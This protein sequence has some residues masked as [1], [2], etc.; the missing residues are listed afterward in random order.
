MLCRNTSDLRQ[1]ICYI[2]NGAKFSTEKIIY[3]SKDYHGNPTLLSG[4]LVRPN[5][6][7]GVVLFYH[8]TTADRKLSPSNYHGDKNIHE[9]NICIDHFVVNGYILLMPDY[10]G[11]GIDDKHCH[12]YMMGDFNS[13]SG[14]DML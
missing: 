1:L 3:P 12:P 9:V 11:L 7:K 2:G 14:I 8:G 10:L 4:L 6:V 5:D 13:L